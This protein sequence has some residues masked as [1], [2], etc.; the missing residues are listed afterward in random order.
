MVI[1]SDDSD[2]HLDSIRAGDLLN[3]WISISSPVK[4]L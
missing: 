4:T 2:E 3:R 1:F